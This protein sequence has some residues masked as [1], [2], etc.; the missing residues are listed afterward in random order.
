MRKVHLGSLMF[1]MIFGLTFMFSKIVLSEVTPMALIAYRFLW[2]ILGME[3]LRRFQVIKITFNKA[4]IKAIAFVVIFQPILYFLFEIY[5][6]NLLKSAEAGMMIALIPVF[7][8]IFS[9]IF[10]KEAPTLFQILFIFVSV[11]GILII[12]WN[13]IS[14]GNPLGFILMLLAVMSAA[15]FN[16]ASR[17]ASKVLNAAEIT[18][19]MMLIGAIVFNIFYVI[20]L[21]FEN[22]I[23]DYFINLTNLQVLFPLLY[24]GLV[25]SIGGF[26]LVNFALKHLEAHVSS[27]Y[28]NL[29]TVISIIAGAVILNEVITLNQAIGSAFILVGVYGTVRFQK[30][31]VNYEVIN[32]RL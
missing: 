18:Y 26:F 15:M 11:I 10:L 21:V 4:H 32:G 6:L 31:K 22:R 1:A 2:A 17:K 3:V 9:S 28:A 19:Y 13:E 25:A 29:A 14:G 24:L 8:A 23:L 20:Q 27:M 12:Q 30:K 16:I 7:V 5:G